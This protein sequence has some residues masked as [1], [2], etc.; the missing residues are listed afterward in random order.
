MSA[1]SSVEAMVMGRWWT[2]DS[3]RDEGCEGGDV[4]EDWRMSVERTSIAWCGRGG[5]EVRRRMGKDTPQ[6]YL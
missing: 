1:P 3:V 5:T 6:V 2:S 4:R